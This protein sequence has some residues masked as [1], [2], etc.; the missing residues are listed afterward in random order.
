MIRAALIAAVLLALSACANTASPV[1]LGASCR[2]A[3]TYGQ[4]D[5]LNATANAVSTVSRI[6]N[7][8]RQMLPRR[9]W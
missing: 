3:P 5:P 8:I 2:P 6:E 7:S 9:G 1:C 4:Q